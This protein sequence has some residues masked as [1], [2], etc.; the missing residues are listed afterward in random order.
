[1]IVSLEHLA[2]PARSKVEKEKSK[3]K[4]KKI[5]FLQLQTS[6]HFLPDAELETK[7]A[8]LLEAI[9]ETENMNQSIVAMQHDPAFIDQQVPCIQLL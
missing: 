9:E 2:T 8:A 4:Q 5:N 1:M 7:K 6:P 3:L